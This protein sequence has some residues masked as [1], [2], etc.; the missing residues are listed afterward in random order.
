MQRLM[1]AQAA[2]VPRP[3]WSL[4]ATVWINGQQ[5]DALREMAERCE[6]LRAEASV[7]RAMA[8]LMSGEAAEERKRAY[9]LCQQTL[10][11][12]AAWDC[13]DA[14]HEQLPA[15]LPYPWLPLHAM[16]GYLYAPPAS[17]RQLLAQCTRRS[18]ALGYA[19]QLAA[20]LLALECGRMVCRSRPAGAGSDRAPHRHGVR[21]CGHGAGSCDRVPASCAVKRL[22]VFVDLRQLG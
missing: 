20:G 22:P 15:Q 5:T 14:L 6:A 2:R 11:Q 9:R 7:L 16:Y 18:A 17:K 13:L 21:L 12:V 10:M 3:A 19:E 8:G 4:A 1:Y